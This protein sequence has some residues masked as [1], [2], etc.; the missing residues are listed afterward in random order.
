MALSSD[1]RWIIGIGATL[2]AGILATV[3]W[4]VLHLT[5]L[6][7]QSEGRLTSRV[8][9]VEDQLTNKI[10]ASETRL[11]QDIQK[12]ETQ[13]LQRIADVDTGLRAVEGETAILVGVETR[14]TEKFDATTARLSENIQGAEKR[15]TAQIANVSTRLLEVEGETAKL[16]GMVET[17][18]IAAQWFWPVEGGTLTEMMAGPVEST[19]EGGELQAV[20]TPTARDV[21]KED[22]IHLETFYASVPAITTYR[23]V[24]FNEAYIEALEKHLA[25]LKAA[26]RTGEGDE[27]TS[28][29]TD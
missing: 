1:T 19:T 4:A 23:K 10:G 12:V 22:F 28:I 21:L 25:A 8:S 29:E 16:T 5:D 7:T 18:S 13:L 9:R 11:S 2:N 15:L 20:A 6:Q 26:Q 3:G 27:D 14:L 24:R 17:S